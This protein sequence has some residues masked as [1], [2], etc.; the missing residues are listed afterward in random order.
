MFDDLGIYLLFLVVGFVWG[1]FAREQQA[2]KRIKQMVEENPEATIDKVEAMGLIPIKIEQHNDTYYVYSV[3]DKTFMAQGK[4]KELLEDNLAK[5]YPGKR[6][7]A[8]PENLKEIGFDN[9]SV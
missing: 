3:K 2:V 1:W 5:R 8:L 4:T 6:F 9:E 7:A